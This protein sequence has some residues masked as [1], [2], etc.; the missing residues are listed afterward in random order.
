VFKSDEHSKKSIGTHKI[1]TLTSP[2]QASVTGGGRVASVQSELVVDASASFDPDFSGSGIDTALQFL[3]QCGMVQGDI[4]V[5]CRDANGLL[6][7]LTYS[8]ALRFPPDFLIAGTTYEFSVS[9]FKS[10]RSAV[11]SSA[12]QIATGAFVEDA[13]LVLVSQTRVNSN[14]KVSI[15]CNSKTV[16]TS[17]QWSI[18]EI[19]AAASL[20]V[21]NSDPTGQSLLLATGTLSPGKDYEVTAFVTAK[22]RQPTKLS[23]GFSVNSPP[24]SGSC[25]VSPGEGIASETAFSISCD[26]WVDVDGGIVYEVVIPDGSGSSSRYPLDMGKS[27]YFPSAGS[28]N[29][30]N[31][32]VVISDKFACETRVVLPVKLSLPL[33]LPV[34]D[35]GVSCKKLAQLGKHSEYAQW[36]D[37]SFAVQRVAASSN[38]SRARHLLQT[39]NQASP[40]VTLM[41]AAV[42]QKVTSAADQA[43]LGVDALS[44]SYLQTIAP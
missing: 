8:R 3:W 20:A 26:G 5:A 21:A 28:S 33:P 42:L 43:P 12:V 4:R 2:L 37:S 9:V 10:G 44:R 11:A 1:Q 24:S 38:S 18:S 13:A 17:Y 31:V 29:V 36:L 40:N 30:L 41:K 15:V 35:V 23:M 19:G 34:D 16:I 14:E 27:V 7:N 22:N 32:S 39:A 25:T 6:L